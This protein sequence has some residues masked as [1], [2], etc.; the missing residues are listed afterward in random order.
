MRDASTKN[1][2]ILLAVCLAAGIIIA[3]LFYIK[4]IDDTYEQIAKRNALYYQTQYPARGL[5][6]DRNNNVLVSNQTIYDITVIPREIRDLDTAELCG[7][8]NINKNILKQSLIDLG[9]KNKN[10]GIASYQ[11]TPISIVPS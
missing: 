1:K 2:I 8:L 10:K 5:I 9:I 6:Y 7:I 11:Q 4:V 3:K